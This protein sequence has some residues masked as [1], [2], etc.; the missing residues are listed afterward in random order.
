MKKV[1]TILMIALT[2]IVLLSCTGTKKPDTNADK[3]ELFYV[4]NSYTET[5]TIIITPYQDDQLF[6][7]VTLY[8]RPREEGTILIR[9]GR[10]YISINSINAIVDIPNVKKVNLRNH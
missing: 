4:N 6:T 9:P 7:Q 3:T 1:A 5:D 10:Y 8:V 2:A